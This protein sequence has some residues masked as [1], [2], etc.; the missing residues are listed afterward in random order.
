MRISHW[1]QEQAEDWVSGITILELV[2][3]NKQKPHLLVTRTRE[4]EERTLTQS[5]TQ[6][7]PL[8]PTANSERPHQ[9]R[10]S[11]TTLSAQQEE[12]KIP[13]GLVIAQPMGA[14]HD[15]ANEKPL[16]LELPV[17]SHGLFLYNSPF[18]VHRRA[19]LSSVPG[20]VCGSPVRPHS[21]NYNFCCSWIN[22]F[23]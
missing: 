8:T 7:S 23:C 20:F 22:P 4:L 6:H 18:Q 3:I 14:R 2:N 9:K 13:P 11:D 21:L 15:S 12:G 16:T 5:V 19:F 17:S 10:G 1:E